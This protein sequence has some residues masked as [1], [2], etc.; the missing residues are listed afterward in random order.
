MPEQESQMPEGAAEVSSPKPPVTMHRVVTK[1]VGC[2]QPCEHNSGFPQDT[3]RDWSIK[4]NVRCE[5]C[6]DQHARKT[7][8]PNMHS[9]EAR[10]KKKRQLD[11]IANKR[12]KKKTVSPANDTPKRK[13]KKRTQCKCGSTDHVSIRHHRCK[14][15]KKNKNKNA[16]DEAA[17]VPTANKDPASP[18]SDDS[19]SYAAKI[20]ATREAVLAK[21]RAVAAASPPSVNN[22]PASPSCRAVAA[23][24]P[25]SVN[26]PSSPPPPPAPTP[27]TP[28]LQRYVPRLGDNVLV[29]YRRNEWYLAHVT[30]ACT[31]S[32][33]FD[34]YFPED[35]KQQQKVPL[36]NIRQV[37][38]KCTEPKRAEL[39]GKVFNYPGDDDVPPS[40]W[41]VRRIKGKENKYFCTC[42]DPNVTPNADD[43]A[44][45]YVISCYKKDRQHRHENPFLNK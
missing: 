37:D 10:A 14:L 7:M 44:I 29:R 25:P 1:C 22:E 31:T 32:N 19:V 18:S 43:F 11:R 5:T 35:K 45:G 41:T 38:P 3:R 26:V 12:K 30:G 17:H 27:P 9:E 40:R 42:L 23:A 13:R 4:T 24:C 28:P 39:V 36:R 20:I 6:W 21:R 15:N 8:I 16:G 2:G 33:Q 34:V